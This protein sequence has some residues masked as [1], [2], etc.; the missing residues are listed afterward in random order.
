MIFK[1]V[2]GSN[3][4]YCL[5][6]KTGGGGRAWCPQNPPM[7]RTGEVFALQLLEVLHIEHQLMVFSRIIPI[8]ITSYL[9]PRPNAF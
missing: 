9:H 1:Q 7:N 8:N 2:Y 6:E 3:N 5:Q 4:N